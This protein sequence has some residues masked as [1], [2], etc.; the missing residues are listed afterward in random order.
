MNNYGPL[1]DDIV[2]NQKLISAINFK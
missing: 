1:Q 2:V